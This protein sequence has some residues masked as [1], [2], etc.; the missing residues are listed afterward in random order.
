[1]KR[2]SVA[3]LASLT[4]L[5]AVGPG[6][7]ELGTSRAW[8]A[9]PDGCNSYCGARAAERCEDLHSLSCGFY[10]MGCLAGCRLRKK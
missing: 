9:R 6:P 4:T 10:M 7:G 2:T 5:T 8:A 1:M 3:L